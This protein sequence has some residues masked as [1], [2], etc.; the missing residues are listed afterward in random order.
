MKKLMVVK[1]LVL[2]RPVNSL[3]PEKYPSTIDIVRPC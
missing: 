1:E 3:C 2:T